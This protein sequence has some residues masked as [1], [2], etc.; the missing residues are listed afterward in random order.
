MDT[1]TLTDNRS[2]RTFEAP[3]R[4]PK[5]GTPAVDIASLPKEFELYSYDP[6]LGNTISCESRITHLNAKEG[7][8]YHRGYPIEELAKEKNY[9]EVCYLLLTGDLPDSSQYEEFDSLIKTRYFLHEKLNRLFTAFPDDSHPMST[10]SSAVAALTSFY[11]NF[12]EIHG[13]TEYNRAEYYIMAQRIIAKIPTIAAQAYRQSI[14]LPSI[15]PDPNRYFTENF[16]YML[17]AYPNHRPK[18]KDIEIKALDTIFTLHADHGQNASTTA[19]RVVCST[20]AHPYA[21]ISAGISALWGPKHGGANEAVIN[22]LKQIGSVEN[23]PKFIQ[24]AKDKN[25]PFRLM[26]F[27]HRIYK[28]YDPR[29]KILKSILEEIKSEIEIDNKLLEIAYE[30]ERIALSD[31]YFISRN[32]YPN[33]DFYSGIILTALKIPLNMFTPIFVIGRS[34]GWVAQW[35]ELRSEE[36]MKITRPRQLYMGDVNKHV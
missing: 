8:L 2:G 11:H 21:A 12:V 1:I 7:K 4:Y 23:V 36:N 25:D 16:L 6:S 17:R 22:Q 13:S 34:V 35:F 20:G 32:L 3:I 24:K 5:G 10:L 33:V 9:L 26:G 30:I 15:Y 14:G 18:I 28:N 29:A 19:V 31:E 27:G